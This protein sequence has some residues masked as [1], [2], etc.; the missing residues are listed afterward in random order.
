MTYFK[1]VAIP[2]D[3]TKGQ[4]IFKITN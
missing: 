1:V 4:T 3:S 2:R